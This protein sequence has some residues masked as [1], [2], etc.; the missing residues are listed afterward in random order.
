MFSALHQT[1]LYTD[2][3]ILSSTG[4]FSELFQRLTYR[5]LPPAVDENSLR[6]CLDRILPVNTDYQWMSGVPAADW[7]ALFNVLDSAG[8]GDE[9]AACK[10]KTLLQL[11]EA[12]QTLS[13]RI[14]AMGLEPE[15]IR[16]Q[17]D[18]ETFE[19][20]FLMQNFEVIR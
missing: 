11:L 7:L 9:D 1:N 10:Q 4:F 8:E 12:I 5:I 6:D 14:S 2:T 20:P 19:S 13:Y 15:L 17:P 18:L 16:N 3:G